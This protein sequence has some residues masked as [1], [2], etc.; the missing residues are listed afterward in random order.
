M[1]VAKASPAETVMLEI[2]D[3]RHGIPTELLIRLREANSETGVGLTG[4]R[5]RLNELNGK[6][7]I[8]SDRHGTSL[9]AI[10][11]LP[12]VAPSVPHEDFTQV[13]FDGET[14]ADALLMASTTG[15]ASRSGRA[16]S[17]F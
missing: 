3:C 2:R 9:R 10:V 15:L 4:T 1:A 7:E 17:G 6:L 16:A 13:T 11:S 12:F 14:M 8:E 5:E